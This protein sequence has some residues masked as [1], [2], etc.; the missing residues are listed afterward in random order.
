[1]KAIK[2]TLI[3]DKTIPEFNR[4]QFM[5]QEVSLRE[6]LLNG[7]HPIVDN[8][9]YPEYY[10]SAL[11]RLDKSMAKALED[12]L[13]DKKNI[14][15]EAAQFSNAISCSPRRYYNDTND[16][17]MPT[18]LDDLSRRLYFVDNYNYDTITKLARRTLRNNWNT[19]T[20]HNVLMH[21]TG[22]FNDTRAF[23]K[24]FDKNI[25]LRSWD[26]VSSL[27]LPNIFNID[28]V[29]G[30]DSA[31]I[32]AAISSPNFRLTGVVDEFI[33]KG[34]LSFRN[35]LKGFSL[36]ADVEDKKLIYIAHVT[37]E[38][39]VQL[40]PHIAIPEDR[41]LYKQYAKSITGKK[42]YCMDLSIEEVESL[43]DNA[44]IGFPTLRYEKVEEVRSSS[45]VVRN[46]LGLTL[47]RTGT[48]VDKD[49]TNK[50][51][52]SILEAY[53]KKVSGVKDELLDRIVDVVVELYRKVKKDLDKYFETPF[54]K[55]SYGYSYQNTSRKKI[56]DPGIDVGS[57]SQMVVA[58]YIARHLRA[59][60]ILSSNWEN[61]SYTIKD[62]V[63]SMINGEVT[64]NHHFIRA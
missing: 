54:V 11:S 4:L 20:A 10:P 39:R 31:I 7:Y 3:P 15:K 53:D 46:D 30:K 47:Y 37:K 9:Y 42:Q 48:M 44:T 27:D 56:F 35:R 57:L 36:Y 49:Y 14:I 32:Y 41:I 17:G 6:M 33:N 29:K 22:S 12:I 19:R 2:V 23:L 18:V 45:A 24:Q 8:E 38:N 26:E 55:L 64:T 5:T 62:L 1:M 21:V 43:Q 51:L 34:Y 13:N 50:T 25:T 61:S 52:I 63:K 58:V 59:E 60:R 16:E 40:I 28:D